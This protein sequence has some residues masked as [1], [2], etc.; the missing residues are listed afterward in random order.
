[1]K[2]ASSPEARFL[3]GYGVAV[4]VMLASAAT[5]NYLVDPYG[6]YG[7]DLLPPYSWNLRQAKVDRLLTAPAAPEVLLLGSSRA[8]SLRPGRIEERCGLTAYNASVPSG[9]L[10]DY[11][12][13]LNAT[14]TRPDAERI[15]YVIVQLDLGTFWDD[16]DVP[17]ELRATPALFRFAASVPHVPVTATVEE[18]LRVLSLS[19]VLDSVKSVRQHLARRPPTLSADRDG[20]VHFASREAAIDVGQYDLKAAIAEEIPYE[21]QLFR[22]GHQ[23]SPLQVRRFQ[24]IAARVHA[25]GGRLIVWLSPSHPALIDALRPLGWERQRHTVLSILDNLQQTGAFDVHDLTTVDRFGGE[26][27][28]F[29]NATHVTTSGGDRILDVLVAGS[30]G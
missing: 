10:I 5:F 18:S 27:S 12:A 16:V 17:F 24:E 20:V 25:N 11:L 28:E 29:L 7:S 2:A 1:M 14:L 4:V 13:L 9:R 15:R 21:E 30:C 6:I 22:E 3:V 23:V 8:F 26:A 19:Q